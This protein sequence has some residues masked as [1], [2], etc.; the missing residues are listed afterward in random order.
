MSRIY[1]ASM[2]ETERI[3]PLP[4]D[5]AAERERHPAEWA[6]Y[7]FAA[8][9]VE[10]KRVLDCACGAGYG[11]ALILRSGAISVAGVDVDDAALAH[12]RLHFAGPTFLK[13]DGRTLPLAD[14]TV[15]LV[16]SLETIEHVKDA[17][18]F[19]DELARVLAPEGMLILSTPLTRGPARLTP[20][21]PYHLREYDEEELAALVSVRFAIAERLGQHSSASRNFAN[22]KAGPGGGVL[23]LGLHRLV[24]RPLRAAARRLLGR[25]AGNER[26]PAAWVS[27]ERWT[28]AP[29]QIVV[30][31]KR[32]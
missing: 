30:A 29:V 27:A 5:A 6:R 25:S 13:G 24:P 10:G 1:P 12:A 21:N 16:V 28:E 4:N 26:G 19:L 8:R 2:D 22:L 15:D 18:L 7:Q 20:Q 32:C 9:E 3:W 31:K 23:R 11:S 17:P 14:G